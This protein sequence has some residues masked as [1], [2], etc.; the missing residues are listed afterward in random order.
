MIRI[1]INTILF[2]LC[3]LALILIAIMAV[4]ISVQIGNAKAQNTL[5]DFLKF[6]QANTNNSSTGNQ[7]VV[8]SDFFKKSMAH[9]ENVIKGIISADEY[10]KE[11]KQ[12]NE[13]IRRFM[14]LNDAEK[15]TLLSSLNYYQSDPMIY[16]EAEREFRKISTQKSIPLWIAILE[17]AMNKNIPQADNPS[18]NLKVA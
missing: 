9:T 4:R 14:Y 5:F 7:P 17:D 8:Q 1:H 16:S 11:D 13:V 18:L 2:I 10:A 15:K 12:G 3:S 6:Q